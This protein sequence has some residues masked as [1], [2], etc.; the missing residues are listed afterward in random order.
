MDDLESETCTAQLAMDLS[1]LPPQHQVDAVGVNWKLL[2]GL[3]LKQTLIRQ[4]LNDRSFIPVPERLP[5]KPPAPRMN[6]VT[7]FSKITFPVALSFVCTTVVTEAALP[8][9]RTS[10]SLCSSKSEI[11]ASAQ[12]YADTK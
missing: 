5:P 3:Y 4:R 11:S 2:Q 12:P 10:M 1:S 7:W 6:T 8:L 9:S